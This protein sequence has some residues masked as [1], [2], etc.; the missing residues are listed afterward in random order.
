MLNLV[1]T[2]AL[3]LVVGVFFK[4]MQRNP[5]YIYIYVLSQYL[6]KIIGSIMIL[7]LDFID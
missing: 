6:I 5:I 1:Q 4:D 3:T 7:T 2:F